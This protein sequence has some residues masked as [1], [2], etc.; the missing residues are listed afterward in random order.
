M[1]HLTFDKKIGKN[2]LFI[3]LSPIIVSISSILMLAIF[4]IGTYGGTF[5]RYLYHLVVQ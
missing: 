2:I 5:L 1:S 3:L 4:N